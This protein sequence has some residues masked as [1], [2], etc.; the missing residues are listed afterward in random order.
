MAL[1]CLGGG[2][3]GC[4]PKDNPL[5]P[6]ERDAVT[7]SPDHTVVVA[8]RSTEVA[9]YPCVEQCHVD[10]QP[11]ATPRAMSEFHTRIRID[12]ASVMRFCDTCHVLEDADE[13]HLLDGTRVEFDASDRVCGQCHGEKHRDWSLGIHGIETGSWNGTA[14]RRACTAC[15]DPHAPLEGIRFNALPVPADVRGG[16]G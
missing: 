7:L 6:E 1:V 5:R 3:V 16:E 9:T 12:H 15:H 2:A 13:F 11:N 8:A 4:E 14:V 10:R